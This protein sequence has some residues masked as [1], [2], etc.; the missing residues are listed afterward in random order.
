MD[1]QLSGSERSPNFFQAFIG[2]QWAQPSV[3]HLTQ[4]LR[5][6]PALI[7]QRRLAKGKAARLH[8]EQH[9]TPKVVASIVAA[10]VQR[11]QDILRQKRRAAAGPIEGC[12]GCQYAAWTASSISKK[13]DVWGVGGENAAAAVNGG[14]GDRGTLG[15]DS[16][17]KPGL[18]QAKH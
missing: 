2:Q 8:I 18:A 11:L 1:S 6:V 15:K 12:G 9:Y 16:P 13:G 4:L 17:V 7:K 5:H 14:G 10:E 3:K